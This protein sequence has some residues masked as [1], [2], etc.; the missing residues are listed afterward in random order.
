MLKHVALVSGL[1]LATSVALAG[2][3]GSMS[4]AQQFSGIYLGGAAGLSSQ[5]YHSEIKNGSNV[6]EAKFDAGEY[7]AAFQLLGGYN[8]AM[9]S[10]WLI[11]GD[12]H[13]QYDTNSDAAHRTSQ[14]GTTGSAHVSMPW[15]FGAA[16]R[17]GYAPMANNL[18]YGLIGPEW[19]RL[20]HKYTRNSSTVVDKTVTD[21][22]ALAAVG[23][24]QK[25]TQHLALGEQVSYIY[26]ASKSNSHTD[27]GKTTIK[28]R[29]IQGL[30]SLM[31]YFS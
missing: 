21:V 30:L 4:P 5:F 1:A 16:L 22:G 17:V 23:A 15:Q 7:G 29:E 25:L 18:F 8:F 6:Q 2:N 27:G 10:H 24:Q 11:G 31:Y 14:S 9:S 20:K 3:A 26:Y 13:G 19:T 28:P 12:I